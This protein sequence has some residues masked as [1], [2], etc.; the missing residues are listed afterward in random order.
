MQP[1]RKSFLHDLLI[2]PT[3]PQRD[4]EKE[5]HAH[6]LLHISVFSPQGQEEH[7][8]NEK[9]IEDMDIAPDENKIVWYHWVGT[10][11]NHAL[12]QFLNRFNIHELVQ[13]DILNPKQQPKFEDYGSYLF[14]AATVFA[15]NHKN[16]MADQVY[17]LLGKNHIIT[18][19]RKPLGLFNKI[20]TV[21]SQNGLPENHF[22]ADFLL[23]LLLD[24]IVDDYFI[25]A[26]RLDSKME[27]IDQK[28]FKQN[29][30]DILPKIHRLKRDAIRLKRTL[31]PLREGMVQ[32]MRGDF[33]LFD[34]SNRIFVRDTLDH[35]VQLNESFDNIRDT[36]QSMMD[37]YLS[38]QSN[39]LNKQ[40]RVLTS[41]TIIF[42]PLTLIAGI[43]GMNFDYMPEL[44][45]RYG[46]LAVCLLMLTITLILLRI[47]Y[48]RH[49]L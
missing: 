20:R 31:S 4:T 49:W 26:E 38:Y 2:Q 39:A 29:N 17:F 13:E 19:Q 21:L 48:R 1:I 3:I 35:C 44:H 15:G 22:R 34:K 7:R 30:A 32:L 23:Y 37:I 40:M 11:Q 10:H 46:Y 43:Y 47:F 16:L 33:P 42:M 36:M 25:A 45:W 28:L 9:Q 18:L 5:E 8:L 6:A 12:N 27:H 14:I 24:R 41:I